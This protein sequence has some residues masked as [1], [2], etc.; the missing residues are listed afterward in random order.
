MAG[1]RSVGR[2]TN[3]HRGGG[4]KFGLLL[5][6]VLLF[7]AAAAI[8]VGRDDGNKARFESLVDSVLPD[9]APAEVT[10]LVGSEKKDFLT[11][12]RIVDAFRDE[13]FNISVSTMG[14][15]EMAQRASEGSLPVHDFY[16]PASDGNTELK[17]FAGAQSREGLHVESN[18]AIVARRDV[19]EDL[20]SQGYL[21][22][23]EG[24]FQANSRE[25]FRLFSSGQRWRDVTNTYQSPRTVGVLSSDPTRSYSSA[26]FAYLMADAAMGGSLRS[27]SSLAEGAS[28]I[29]P[30]FQ[31]QGL[32]EGSS[33]DSFNQFIAGSGQDTPMTV[34]YDSQFVAL[35]NQQPEQAAEFALINLDPTVRVQHELVI[36]DSSVHVEESENFIHVL[37]ENHDVLT[38]MMEYGFAPAASSNY[39]ST[40]KERT[41]D[42]LPQNLQ[43]LSPAPVMQDITRLAGELER[44]M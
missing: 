22:T 12:P 34:A 9:G 44:L 14:S 38:V 8:F 24:Q 26:Q 2:G 41:R 35:V 15:L 29:A 27:P 20:A 11:D 21:D 39:S 13:G 19:A 30:I 3:G 4:R 16:F 43:Y 36:N 31:A 40:F 25:L 28:R 18:I 23:A 10:L 17:S 32:T 42:I 33:G 7:I 5:G 37:E 1:N 6:V